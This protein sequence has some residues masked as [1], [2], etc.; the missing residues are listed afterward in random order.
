MV[1]L[2]RH[3]LEVAIISDEVMVVVVVVVVVV[4]ESKVWECRGVGWG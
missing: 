4:E 2:K 1:I 3:R